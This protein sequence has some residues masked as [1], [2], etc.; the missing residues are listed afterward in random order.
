MK[1]VRAKIPISYLR[2]Y[3]RILKDKGVLDLIK[4]VELLP[5]HLKSKIILNLY[6]KIDLK[7]PSHI[8]EEDLKKLLPDLIIWH[9]PQPDKK[10]FNETDIYCLPHREGLRNQPLGMAVSRPILTTNA[11]GCDDTVEE[12]INGFKVNTG[13]YMALS[14]K[15]KVLIENEEIRIQMGL[16]SRELFLEKFTLKKVISDTFNLYNTLIKTKH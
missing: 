2:L 16:K 6:G 9:G 14:E 12:G 1:Y 8:L 4:A 5:K 10:G 15:L 3:G 11:P 7:N 13:D